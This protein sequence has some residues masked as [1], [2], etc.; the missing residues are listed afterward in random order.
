[1]ERVDFDTSAIDGIITGSELPSNLIFGGENGNIVSDT[2]ADNFG[3]FTG[4][5][6]MDGG[7]TGKWG[8][9]FY[10]DGATSAA[11]TFGVSKGTAGEED[12]DSF[13]GYF[14]APKL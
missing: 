4:D 1:M 7:Y 5:T 3:S 10:S 14:S 2:S 11:G 8:G 12:F 6:N 9:N 13:V